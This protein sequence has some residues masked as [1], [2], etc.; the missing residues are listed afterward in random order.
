MSDNNNAGWYGGP[1]G[2][3]A[4]PRHAPLASRQYGPA[5]VADVTTGTTH[6]QRVEALAT[7]GWTVSNE[8]TPVNRDVIAAAYARSLDTERGR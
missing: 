4:T 3:G 6:E 7:L 5:H 2:N 8:D 1:I